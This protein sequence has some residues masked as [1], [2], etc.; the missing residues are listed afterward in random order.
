[1][2]ENTEVSKDVLGHV[3]AL[4]ALLKS[5]SSADE[6]AQVRAKLAIVKMTYRHSYYKLK[7]RFRNRIDE[8]LEIAFTEAMG[9]YE[10]SA[11]VTGGREVISALT[12]MYEL[13]RNMEKWAGTIK[14]TKPK[15]R[16]SIFD[17]LDPLWE[18]LIAEMDDVTIDLEDVLDNED[19]CKQWADKLKG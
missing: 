9:R 16:D 17:Q 14:P 13:L 2:A 7:K 11:L 10:G 5:Y 6:A 4:L 8:K 15:G 18:P 1:M 3:R 12:T 19:K